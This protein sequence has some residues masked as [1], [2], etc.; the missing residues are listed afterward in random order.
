MEAISLLEQVMWKLKID[1]TTNGISNKDESIEII[2]L[3][4][5]ANLHLDDAMD[6][7]SCRINC[8]ADIVIANM[9][10]FLDKIDE[11]DFSSWR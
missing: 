8:R 11:E 10:P 2:E 6:R 4:P 9:L 3:T 7:Q 5:L 1:E